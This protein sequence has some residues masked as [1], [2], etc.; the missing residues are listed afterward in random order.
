MSKPE[1]NTTEMDQA[2]RSFLSGAAAVTTLS[3][4]PGVTLMA[5]AAPAAAKDAH[6][7][8]SARIRWGMLIDVNKCGSDCSACVD[9][10]KEEHGWAD[11]T[12]REAR[13]KTDA[14]WIR[15][16]NVR[17]PKT[18]RKFSLPIMCQHCEKPA[19]ADVC[20][21]GASFQRMDGIV[22]VDKHLCIGCRYCMMACPY[23]ARSFVHENVY[24]QKP[25]MPRGKGTVEACT[26]C[27]HR[28]DVGGIPACAE[29]CGK[30]GHGAILFGDLNDPMSEIAKTVANF[31]SKQI[32]ADLGMNPS[33]RY[34]GI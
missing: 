1:S 32:R 12:G 23:K 5:S 22:L 17:D 7:A 21:T 29:R 4:A 18:N 11:T 24:N 9:A 6:E 10:C 8:T 3:L 27:V 34:R 26:M 19:C 20:P 16:A 33:I 28:I 15:K 31:S 14:Q 2:R 25:H 13:P 30:D